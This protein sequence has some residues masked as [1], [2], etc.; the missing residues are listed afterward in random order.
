MVLDYVLRMSFD[1]NNSKGF[2]LHPRKSSR[3]LAVYLTDTDFADDIALISYSIQDAQTLLN[4]LESVANCVGMNE[5]L[6]I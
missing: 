1:K 6:N 5:K 3:N 4:S 2:Q